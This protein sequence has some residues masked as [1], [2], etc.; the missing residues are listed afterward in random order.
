MRLPAAEVRLK[1]DHRVAALR[2]QSLDAAHEQ[3]LQALG[4]VGPPE[5]LLRLAVLLGPLAEVDLPQI[6]S[7]LRLL[8][9]PAGHVGVRRHDLAPRLETT[10]CRGLHERASG[11]ALLAAHLLVEDEPAQLELHRADLVGLW[12]RDR[13]QQPRHR[14]E[15]AVGVVARERLLVPHLLRTSRSSE[16]SVRSA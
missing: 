3:P 10:R 6:G 12:R 5:E 15:R 8:V 4:Q 13:R 1:L 16:T 7:E 2:G 9:A 14:V 11:L